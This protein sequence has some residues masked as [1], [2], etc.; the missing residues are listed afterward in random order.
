MYRNLTDKDNL[1]FKI[2]EAG[3]FNRFFSLQIAAGLATI[4][5]KALIPYGVYTLQR[6][7]CDSSAEYQ[8]YGP[9]SS[10]VQKKTT[11]LFDM[12][13]YDKDLIPFVLDYPNIKTFYEDEIL[14]D[15][16]FSFLYTV[17]QEQE[18]LESHFSDNRKKIFL[19]NGKNYNIKGFTLCNY[20]T[21]FMNRSAK[22]DNAISKIKIKN[23]Y[24]E[25]AKKIHDDIGEFNGIHVRLTDHTNNQPTTQEDLDRSIEMLSDKKI[26]ILTDEMNHEYF[27]NYKNVTFFDDLM[28]KNYNREFF[29]L[30]VQTEV[31]W[32]IVGALLMSMSNDFIGTKKSTFTS[33]IQREMNQNK[34]HNFKFLNEIPDDSAKPFSWL[35]EARSGHKAYTLSR[36]WKESRFMI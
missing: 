36:D 2:H 26:I 8:F 30:G 4:Y 1:F 19:E 21:F 34:D 18:K 11:G 20:S 22:L 13:D 24:Y 10:M 17:D 12:I 15:E 23:E 5:N 9:R 33:F 28:S 29:S 16:D 35:N 14:I 31:S 32:S 25:L 27:K 6:R 7:S 3:F